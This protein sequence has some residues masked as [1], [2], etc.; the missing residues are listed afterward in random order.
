MELGWYSHSLLF[1]SPLLI[2]DCIVGAS[3]DFGQSLEHV[4]EAATHTFTTQQ[5]DIKKKIREKNKK[6]FNDCKQ[7]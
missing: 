2:G 4:A 5:L 1:H 6:I 7:K 3:K